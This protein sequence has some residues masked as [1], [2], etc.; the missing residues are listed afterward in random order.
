MD[1]DSGY[2][3]VRELGIGLSTTVWGLKDLDLWVR[4]LEKLLD[5]DLRRTSGSTGRLLK[6]LD[7]SYYWGIWTRGG[8]R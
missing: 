1:G 5:G 7:F 6:D 4:G 3:R 8:S 2:L